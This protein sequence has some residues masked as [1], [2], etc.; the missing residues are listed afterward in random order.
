MLRF[1]RRR[2]RL[3]QRELGVAVGYSEAQICR[4]EQTR[5]LPDPTTVA[6]LFLPAL[7]LADEP[8]L[9]AR[10]L[11][12]AVSARAG[13]HLGRPA[14]RVVPAGDVPAGDVPGDVLPGGGVRPA[15][16][17]GAEIVPGGD[18]RPA[19]SGGGIVP[20][21]GVRPA[22][23]PASDDG[24]ALIVGLSGAVPA[25]LADRLLARAGGS[26]TLL[27]LA[28]G[29]LTGD[30]PDPPPLVGRLA[31]QPE[32]AS[33]L[34]E[35]TL[36]RLDPASQ[37]LVALLSV[38]RRPVDLH[39][40]TLLE[41][42]HAADGP[43]DLLAAIGELQR[44]QIIDHPARAV[45]HPLIRDHGY[46]NLISDVSRRRRLHRIAAEWSV[47]VADD[48]LEAAWHY[49]RADEPEAAADLLAARL[50]AL[51]ECGQAFTAGDLT[52]HLLR[53]VRTPGRPS[54]RR[55]SAGS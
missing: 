14:G 37:R 28:L 47:R 48:V 24:W 27:R 35:T 16:R 7:R 11:A 4:L 32:V 17:S 46:A 31:A 44:R 43:F 25:G 40:E 41:L 10:L 53:A 22:A 50:T 1:L 55:G 51:V 42:C 8:E 2:A 54:P 36:G 12:L 13:R 26:P 15:A 38:F 20:R 49:T 23:S 34:V 45:L 52:A 33:Y 18:A 5:R 30:D 39:D 3:T 6:A 29:Q 9:A 21:D 19:G